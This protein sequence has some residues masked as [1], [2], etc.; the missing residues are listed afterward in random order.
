MAIGQNNNTQFYIVTTF[1]IEL[2]NARIHAFTLPIYLHDVV[3][4]SA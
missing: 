3:I 1:N 4:D 2:K